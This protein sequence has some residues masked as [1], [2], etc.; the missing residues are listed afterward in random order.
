MALPKAAPKVIMMTHL[1][2]FEAPVR[3]GGGFRVKKK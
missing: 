1:P 2:K 3:T